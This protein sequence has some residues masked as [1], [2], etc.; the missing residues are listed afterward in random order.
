MQLILCSRGQMCPTRAHALSRLF[1]GG[2]NLLTWCPHYSKLFSFS[3]VSAISCSKVNKLLMYTGVH[4]DSLNRW[5]DICKWFF[6]PFI[7]PCLYT[8]TLSIQFRLFSGPRLI[9]LWPEGPLWRPNAVHCHLW[10]HAMCSNIRTQH[11]YCNICGI[12]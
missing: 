3:S 9:W 6:L 7:F 4:I 5:G 11:N 2:S 10:K 12:T 8:V 1:L